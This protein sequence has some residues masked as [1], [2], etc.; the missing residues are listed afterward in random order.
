[1]SSDKVMQ[2]YNNIHMHKFNKKRFIIKEISAYKG[3]GLKE[4]LNWLFKAMTEFLYLKTI[5][6]DENIDNIV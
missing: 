3:K 1:M 6:K 2:I 4:S 5:K